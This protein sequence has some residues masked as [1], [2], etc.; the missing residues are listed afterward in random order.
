[1]DGWMDGH[2]NTYTEAIADS[3]EFTSHRTRTGSRGAAINGA[4]VFK[5]EPDT[6]RSA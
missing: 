6:V 4:G 2:L 1:M 5:V 3:G